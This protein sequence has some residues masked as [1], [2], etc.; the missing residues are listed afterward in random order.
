MSLLMA[1]RLY[2]NNFIFFKMNNQ[3]L[4]IKLYCTKYQLID[5]NKTNK[6]NYLLTVI[7]FS[8]H[9]NNKKK[10]DKQPKYK[11]SFRS[12]SYNY[13]KTILCI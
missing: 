12:K 13:V 4:S 7:C 10:N 8:F 1:T 11:F 3:I 9:L 5:S 6:T 2:Y